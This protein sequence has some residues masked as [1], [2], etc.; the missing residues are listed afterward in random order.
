GASLR[1]LRERT[2]IHYEE[3][4]RG[5]LHLFRSSAERRAATG[6]LDLLERHGIAAHI[7]EADACADIDPSLAHIA[8]RLNGALYAPEDESGNACLFTRALATLAHERGVRFHLSTAIESF[9]LD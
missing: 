8:P 9:A 5:I 2:G 1:A 6:R 7:V 3:R 4:A